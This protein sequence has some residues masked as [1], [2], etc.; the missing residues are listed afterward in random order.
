MQDLQFVF[1]R[2]L[3][4]ILYILALYV[5]G[6]GFTEYQSMFAGLVLGTILGTFN[7]WLLARKTTQVGEAAARGQTVRSMG[8]ASRYASAILGAIIAIK[9][10]EYVNI[11]GTVLGLVTAYVVMII[12]FIIHKS[13]EEKG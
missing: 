13:N 10:P 7:L 4:Y 8:S 9:Y 1:R 2:Q 12:D 3:K 6:W 11:I 5:L